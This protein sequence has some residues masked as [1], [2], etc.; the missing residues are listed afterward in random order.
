M[1]RD[2][3][4]YAPLQ[5]LAKTKRPGLKS[6]A[7][8]VLGIDIQTDEHSSVRLHYSSIYSFHTLPSSLRTPT[9]LVGSLFSQRN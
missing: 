4:K 1:T 5:G 8:L 2:T 7:K 9:I 6:L 3:A